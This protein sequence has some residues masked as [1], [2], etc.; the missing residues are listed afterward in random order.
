M[1]WETSPTKHQPLPSIITRT[2]V[3]AGA[4][5]IH[6]QSSYAQGVLVPFSHKYIMIFL[7]KKET[8]KRK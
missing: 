2:Q 5:S 3:I 1:G 7:M 4:K 8:N 6:G